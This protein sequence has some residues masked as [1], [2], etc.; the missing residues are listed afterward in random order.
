M[1]QRKGNNGTSESGSLNGSVV[2]RLPLVAYYSV[3]CQP[4]VILEM[5]PKTVSNA[6]H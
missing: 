2:A 4:L 5:T 1:E 3:T 6:F